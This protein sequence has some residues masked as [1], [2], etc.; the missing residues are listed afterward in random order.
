[1]KKL[2][3]KDIGGNYEHGQSQGMDSEDRERE[4][5]TGTK[6]YKKDEQT[7]EHF[8]KNEVSVTG[9]SNVQ[10]FPWSSN[11]QKNSD[12]LDLEHF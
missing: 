2:V 10:C 6:R 7:L 8:G 5:T 1:V 11:T 12:L 9:F 3:Q 4:G